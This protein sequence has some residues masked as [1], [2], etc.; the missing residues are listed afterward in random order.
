MKHIHILHYIVLAIILGA[1]LGAFLYASP[2][3]ALQFIVGIVIAVS[4]VIWGLIHHAIEKDLH[5]KVV[6][7]YI[8]IAAIAI[9]LLATILRT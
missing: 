1:G 6:V 5:Q 2:D 3:T 8:L 7:E 4:Y 9:V